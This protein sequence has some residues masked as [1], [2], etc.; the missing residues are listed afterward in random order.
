MSAESYT[1]TGPLSLRQAATVWAAAAGI[2]GAY[3]P[4]AM[5]LAAAV[6]PGLEDLRSPAQI[7]Q[8]LADDAAAIADVRAAR[9]ADLCGLPRPSDLPPKRAELV[10][11]RLVW[12]TSVTVALCPHPS[13]GWMVRLE[14]YHP[15]RARALMRALASTLEVAS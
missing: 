9:A 13:G 1:E 2:N 14:G 4:A 12:E 10:H 6:W 7:L 5:P 8:A 11:G 3:V 15:E